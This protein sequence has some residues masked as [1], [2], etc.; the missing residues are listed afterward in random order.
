MS[1]K[2]SF[3]T[4]REIRVL[5]SMLDLTINFS[6]VCTWKKGKP[7]KWKSPEIPA[8][9][10]RYLTMKF[11]NLKMKFWCL[12]WQFLYFTTK[13]L[14]P[15][16]DIWNIFRVTS[17]RDLGQTVLSFHWDALPSHEYIH[18]QLLF[19]F[20]AKCQFFF[21]AKCQTLSKK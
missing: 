11:Q 3:C 12:V 18:I 20:Y 1:T 6:L 16:L 21:D 13:F 5:K 2:N 19:F 17:L 9:A 14:V 10:A 15:K 7:P 4:P 8:S